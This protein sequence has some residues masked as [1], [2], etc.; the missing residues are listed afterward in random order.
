MNIII[1]GSTR[2]LGLFLAEEL[3]KNGHSVLI[4]SRNRMD[5]SLISS[6]LRIKYPNSIIHIYSC[7]IT[8]ENSVKRMFWEANRYFGSVDCWI[9]CVSDLNID[10]IRKNSFIATEFI[11]SNE[12]LIYN[13]LRYKKGDKT[14]KKLMKKITKNINKD[15]KN[16]SASIIKIGFFSRRFEK[17]TPHLIKKKLF[18]KNGVIK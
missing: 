7:D 10:T 17:S 3:I 5:C 2:G 1:V 6:K 14:K 13:L 18:T 11:K 4:N 15:F 8:C 12:G 16:I 9:S